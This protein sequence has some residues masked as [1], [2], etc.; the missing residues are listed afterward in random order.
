[1]LGQSTFHRLVR[2][3]YGRQ[4]FS[5]MELVLVVAVIMIVAS[6]LIP[7]LIDA[8]HKAKQ[9]RTMAD[10]NSI[11]SAWMSWLTD[12]VGAASA[13]AP[14]VYDTDGFIEVTYQE[15]FNYLHPTE[16]FFYMNKVPEV[17]GWDSRMGFFRNP[18]TL[19]D[20][21]LMICASA[22]DDVFDDCD[23]DQPIEIGPFLATNFDR[24]IIWADGFFLRWPELASN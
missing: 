17:D 13:G 10:L 16:T 8:I 19:S 1:M 11:G 14:K 12:Q 23:V 7:H 9:R 5:L 22:R 3:R 6:I 20:N 24:D 21:Q 2:R 18:A 4:G 15:L